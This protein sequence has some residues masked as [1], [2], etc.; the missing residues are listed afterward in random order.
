MSY[1]PT[2]KPSLVEPANKLYLEINE[3]GTCSDGG[4]GAIWFLSYTDELIID[5]TSTTYFNEVTKL[6]PGIW[7]EYSRVIEPYQ[8]KI[9]DENNVK[10]LYLTSL[11]TSGT[12]VFIRKN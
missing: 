7:N 5:S 2:A 4:K 8:V 10:Y 11:N 6:R 9:N 3:D 12:R 1:N